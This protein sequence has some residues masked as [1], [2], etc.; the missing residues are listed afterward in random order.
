MYV[1][2]ETIV[3]EAPSTRQIGREK[4]PLGQIV[5]KCTLLELSRT[6]DHFLWRLK[7]SVPRYSPRG[8]F[9][10]KPS[11]DT[12]YGPHVVFKSDLQFLMGPNRESLLKLWPVLDWLLT[13]G[14]HICTSQIAD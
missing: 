10:E 9:R 12:S 1:T 6:S 2:T 3:K 5:M 14:G 13:R 4:N 7:I 11:N 8:A